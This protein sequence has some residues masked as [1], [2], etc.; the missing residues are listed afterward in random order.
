MKRLLL[1]T[2]VLSCFAISTIAIQISCNKTID[3]Q[4]TGSTP[5]IIG[6]FIFRKVV[7]PTGSSY[8]SEIWI[9]NYDGTNA[10]KVNIVLPTGVFFD[11]GLTLAMS[12]NGQKIFFTA[13]APD[14]GNMNVSSRGD[15]YSC[16]VDG[17]GV[18][19]IID[20]G[21]ATNRIQIGNAY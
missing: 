6:K 3:A 21:G 17:S 2:L 1:S 8:S 7:S 10:S 4:T 16:N 20:K 11:D 14:A 19:K 5:S 9:A 12:P 13:G 18:T 15:L